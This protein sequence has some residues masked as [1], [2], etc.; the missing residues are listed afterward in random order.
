MKLNVNSPEYYTNEHGVDDEIYWM[1]RDIYDYFKDK[2]YSNTIKIVGICPIIAPQEVIDSGLCK[3]YKHCE[4][5]AG[6]ASVGMQIDYNDYIQADI[7][8]K[9]GLIIQNILK[10]IKSVSARG[11]IDYNRFEA[12]LKKYCESKDIE[13]ILPNLCN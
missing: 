8:H 10:S 2:E 11:K 7:S 3:E 4:Q 1:C 12:D 5:K 13:F 6:F 9:R